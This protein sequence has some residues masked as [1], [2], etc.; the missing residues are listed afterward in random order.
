MHFWE[1]KVL[2][3]EM[4]LKDSESTTCPRIL[5]FR[6]QPQLQCFSTSLNS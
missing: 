1:V 3:Q 4:V 2:C 6:I 5:F